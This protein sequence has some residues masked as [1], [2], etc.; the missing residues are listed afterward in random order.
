MH[1]AVQVRD[2]PVF[3]FFKQCVYSFPLP[4]LDSEMKNTM[5]GC[6]MLCVCLC[7]NELPLN[8]VLKYAKFLLKLCSYSDC[9]IN[10][11]YVVS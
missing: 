1:V 5:A 2:F 11:V 9:G 7:M 4:F 10:V 6:C 3:F 8:Y